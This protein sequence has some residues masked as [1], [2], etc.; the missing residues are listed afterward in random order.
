ME[1]S[2]YPWTKPTNILELRAV[3]GLLYFRGLFGMNHHGLNTLLY[4]KAGPP[5]FS[6]T[7]SRNRMKFLL[8]TLTFDDRETRKEKWPYD[9]FAAARP[10][11]EMFNSNTCKYLLLSLYL[12]IDE[13]L[14]LMRHKIA[15]GSAR[16]L[17]FGLLSDNRW[18]LVAFYYILDTIHVN[19]E[20]L[21]CI[22]KDLDL[23]KE[24]TF[25]L[26]FELA[27]SLTYPLIGQQRINGLRKSVNTEN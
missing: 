26:E 14:Y 2:K 19:F 23:K 7:M 10:I 18:D 6:A 11:F 15:F 12:S 5:I 8:S 13:I 20:S 1:S 4:D 21:F 3:I 17:L 24:N 25:D 22:K 16:C 9:R 27:K